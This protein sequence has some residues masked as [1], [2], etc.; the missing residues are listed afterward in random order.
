MIREDQRLL[1]LD[2]PVGRVEELFPARVAG[3][4]EAD[5]DHRAALGLDGFGDQVHVGLLGGAAAFLDVALDAAADNVF[6]AAAAAL[7][8]RD[9]VVERE[10]SG[11]HALAAILAAIGVARVDVAA[12]K[13]DV[14]AG[15]LVVA[16]QADDARDGDLEADGVDPVVLIRLKLGL[17]LADFAPALEVEILPFTL[18]G[19]VGFDV[20]DLSHLA[21][22]HGEGPA[23]VDDSNGLIEAVEHQ[24]IG[25]QRGCTAAV[26]GRGVGRLGDEHIPLHEIVPLKF[27]VSQ[28]RAG[29]GIYWG[30]WEGV[31]RQIIC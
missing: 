16:E 11:A 6:P 19:G 1:Q 26:S 10:L 20:D 9:D 7:A 4:S 27:G 14:L 30:T 8:A 25:A 15:K 24:D 21:A 3:V 2:G 18:A 31:R 29:R 23:D 13:F 22:E 5:I 28:S 17:E 12:V